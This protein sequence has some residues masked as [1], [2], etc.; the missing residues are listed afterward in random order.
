MRLLLVIV[1]M[2]GACRTKDTAKPPQQPQPPA[3]A[4]PATE[5]LPPMPAYPEA[6]RGRLA[7]QSAGGDHEIKGEWPAQAGACDKPPILQVVTQEKGIGTIVVLELPV[8]LRVTSYPVTAIAQGLPAPPASQVGVQLFRPEGPS[9][10][11]ATEGTVDV[12]AYEKTVSG[13]F[14]VTLRQVSSSARIRYAGA[15]REIP[16]RQ[17]DPAHCA[18][19]DSAGSARR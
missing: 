1:S 11:Q 3:V 9:A 8:K 16:I 6:A 18:V 19:S 12:S 13:R 17:L 5:S 15:F 14:G 4:R 2:L 7:V 10:Y